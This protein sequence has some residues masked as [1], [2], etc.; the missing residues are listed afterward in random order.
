MTTTATGEPVNNAP[1]APAGEPQGQPV[2]TPAP[3]PSTPA[4]PEKFK[5][6]VG[7]LAAAYAELERKLGSQAVPPGFKA[8]AQEATQEAPAETPPATPAV[9][10]GDTH[11]SVAQAVKAAGLDVAE[12]YAEY[13]EKG[14]LSP[15]S[16]EKLAKAGI[17]K[18]AVSEAIG[19]LEAANAKAVAETLTAAG[20][21]KEE[22]GQLQAWAAANLSDEAKRGLDAVLETGTVDAIRFAISTVRDHYTR[23]FAGKSPKLLTGDNAG[24]AQGTGYA[25][26]AEQ[27]TA[28]RDPRYRTDPAYRAEVE[29]RLVHTPRW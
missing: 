13:E 29:R 18:E 12:F 14:A 23:S 1:A 7:A 6:D 19:K 20:S 15:A 3:A 17:T 11:E 16:Y 22:W 21:S 5:G 27:M 9:S 2:T 25:S 8:P 4:I 24:P 10:L 28:M 26:L